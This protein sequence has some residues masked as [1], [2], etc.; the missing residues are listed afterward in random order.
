[1]RMFDEKITEQLGGDSPLRVRS[2]KSLKAWSVSDA[3][4]LD[5]CGG[6]R[7]RFAQAWT[8]SAKV[9]FRTIEAGED[10]SSSSNCRRPE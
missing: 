1:V 9:V 4:M 5:S 10:Q 8:A 7:R 3:N 6:P 2:A